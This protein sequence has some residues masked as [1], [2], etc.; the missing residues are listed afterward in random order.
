[1][2]SKGNNEVLSMQQM[3]ED[4]ESVKRQMEAIERNSIKAALKRHNGKLQ[5]A[6]DYLGISLNA[7]QRKVFKYNI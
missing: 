1:M 4:I 2:D 7:L 5:A 3:S 6:A